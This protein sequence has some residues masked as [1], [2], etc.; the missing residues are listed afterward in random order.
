MIAD[1][2][3]TLRARSFSPTP[4]TDVAV[5]LTVL[6]GPDKARSAEFDATSP[7]PF[8][9]GTSPACALVLT[10]PTVSRRHLSLELDGDGGVVLSDLDSSNGTRLGALHVGTVTLTSDETLQLGHTTLRVE[11]L[12]QQRKGE[13]PVQTSFGRYFGAST[14]MRRLY[15]MLSRLAGASIPTLIEGETGT[16][17]ELLAEALHE[18]GPR[19]KGPF[20]VFDCAA[21][22]PSVMESELFGHE[23]GA[24]SG[25][26]GRRVGLAELAHKGTLLI[27]EVGEL[28]TALQ[29]KLLRLI[30]RGEVRPVGGNQVVQ[31]D[32]RVLAATR[33]DLDTEVALGRFRDDLFHRLAVGR[34]T[35]PPLRKRRGDITLLARRFVNDFG[36]DESALSPAVLNRWELYGWPGNVRELRNAVQRHL[37][38]GEVGRAEGSTAHV[39]EAG[40]ESADYL[41]ALLALDLQL[42][43]AR[44]RLAIEFE[45]RYVARALEKNGGNVTRAA[46]SSGIARRHFQHLKSRGE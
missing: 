24:F 23:R 8:L 34:V 3:S 7:A 27:D 4:L 6:E 26:T 19:A 41:Q 32:L 44:R 13:L 30:D 42:P 40:P 46:R 15:P 22:A 10:D 5:R 1:D 17:K 37:A 35:L 38:L 31:V 45:R 14:E 20:V 12:G 28:S 2:V 11:R 25:A 16:G 36:Y 43:E 33:R 21:V 39:E 9:V 18:E 29:P